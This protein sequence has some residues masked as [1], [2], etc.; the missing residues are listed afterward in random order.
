MYLLRYQAENAQFR[1]V[2]A[3]LQKGR[4][5]VQFEG[6]S[7]RLSCGLFPRCGLWIAPRSQRKAASDSQRT[8]GTKIDRGLALIS[9]DYDTVGQ[10]GTQDASWLYRSMDSYQAATLRSLLRLC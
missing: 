6:D 10:E 7:Q 1:T 3:D 5:V 9:I 4:I 2:D 8:S